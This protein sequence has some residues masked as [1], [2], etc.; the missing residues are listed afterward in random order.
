MVLSVSALALTVWYFLKRERNIYDNR[1]YVSD[2]DVGLQ[3]LLS[4]LFLFFVVCSIVNALDVFKLIFVPEIRVYEELSEL[5][6][7]TK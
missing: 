4:F 5:Y 1:G 7:K 3:V 2:T 6:N